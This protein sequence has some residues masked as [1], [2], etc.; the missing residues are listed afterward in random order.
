[1][2]NF[3]VLVD[4][5][6]DYTLI[7][8]K[9]GVEKQKYIIRKT[10]YKNFYIYSLFDINSDK[11]IT[12]LY[13]DDGKAINPVC[14]DIMIYLKNHYKDNHTLYEVNDLDLIELF[15]MSIT[16]LETAFLH[17]RTYDN[18]TY[19]LYSKYTVYT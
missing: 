5:G 14:K 7:I 8:D 17:K 18:Y 13:D 12:R 9:E 2:G 16:K 11:E 4:K 10:D 15:C 3:T 1:M 19:K 6:T